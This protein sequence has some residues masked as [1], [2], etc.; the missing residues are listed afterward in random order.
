MVLTNDSK[1]EERLKSYR[2][3]GITKDP[4]K[5]RHSSPGP[6]YFESQLIGVNNNF[7]EM[8]AALGRSQLKRLS[9]NLEKRHKL[10]KKYRSE[11]SNI[12]YISLPN[13]RYDQESA[14][15]IYFIRIDFSKVKI[16]KST[17]MEKLHEKG[18]GTQVHYIPIYRHP[19]FTDLYGDLKHQYDQMELFYS[20]ALTLPLY[21][22]LN[23]HEVEEICNLLKGLLSNKP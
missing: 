6:W 18:V 14:Q 21:Y 9:K 15:N 11:L 12:E 8:Q 2:N 13:E 5:L 23:E 10:A 4:E 1:L 17:L 20:Q 7:T 3:N 22:D 16:D 19:F